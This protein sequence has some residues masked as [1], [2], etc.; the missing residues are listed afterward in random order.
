MKR[1]DYVNPVVTEQSTA[2]VVVVRM[3][4]V[5]IIRDGLVRAGGIFSRDH[6][7]ST[8]RHRN[9]AARTETITPVEPQVRLVRDGIEPAAGRDRDVSLLNARRHAYVAK[10]D[11]IPRAT[12]AVDTPTKFLATR[13]SLHDATAHL[14]MADLANA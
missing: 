12:V 1:V 11:M 5:A 2:P 10:L 4:R 13:T 6:V 3:T 9:H 14:T 8:Q 7:R